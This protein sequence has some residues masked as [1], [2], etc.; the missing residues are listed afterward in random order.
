MFP[1]GQ[2]K[3]MEGEKKVR[4]KLIQ[5]VYIVLVYSLKIRRV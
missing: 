1:Q 4:M 3:K 5:N 2:K